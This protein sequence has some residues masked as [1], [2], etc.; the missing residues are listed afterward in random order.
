MKFIMIKNEGEG[1]YTVELTHATNLDNTTKI[2]EDKPSLDKFIV[3]MRKK[4]YTVVNDS[5]V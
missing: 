4:G 3:I 5:W 1:F 2:F